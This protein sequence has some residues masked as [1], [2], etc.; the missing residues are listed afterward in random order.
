[1]D[2]NYRPGNFGVF[3]YLKDEII[4]RAY[5]FSSSPTEDFLQITVKHIPNG[6]M[7]SYLTGLKVGDSLTFNAPFG[8]FMFEDNL[9]NVVFIAGG[10]GISMFRSMIKYILDKKLDTKIILIYG[11]KSPNEIIL[12][13]WLEELNR[14][15]YSFKLFL[16]IDK[17]DPLWRFHTGF[18]N[19]DFIMEATENNV[20]D[21]V[22]F[23]CGPPVMITS[24]KNALLKANVRGENIRLD[25]WG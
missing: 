3:D 8:K 25:A 1:V 10:S 13:D 17:P 6:K 20:L 15:I 21:K 11:S 2:F 4:R 23:L 5:S 19:L 12:W 9:K 14:T 22:Y 16:T 7:S 24:V 18:I